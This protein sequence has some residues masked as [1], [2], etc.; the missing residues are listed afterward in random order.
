M[1]AS[2]WLGRLSRARSAPLARNDPRRSHD[3]HAWGTE[4]PPTAAMR[5]V[6]ST[7]Y[8]APA[9]VQGILGRRRPLFRW[10]F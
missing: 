10:A 4:I 7:A 8:D 2:V 9:L 5:F 6:V 1:S 3:T